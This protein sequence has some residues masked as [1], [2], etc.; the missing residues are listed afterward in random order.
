MKHRRVFLGALM[1]MLA[2]MT[3]IAADSTNDGQDVV[4][5]VRRYL[6]AIQ[7]GE[8][9]QG[10]IRTAKA[11]KGDTST[12][13]DRLLAA[14]PQEIEATIAP[15]FAAR[16]TLEQARALADFYFSPV[17]E[18]VITQGREHVNQPNFTPDLS[19]R[20]TRELEEFLQTPAGKLS[21]Q[22]TRDPAI[23]NE[24]FKLLKQ[25]YGQ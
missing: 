23:R 8:T 18:K 16:V 15:A 6:Q 17:G 22:L 19:Q 25:K 1:S 3:A 5:E 11:N 13:M 24:Y 9:L 7:F 10:G 14:S 2:T 20:E 21:Q 12:S 4:T